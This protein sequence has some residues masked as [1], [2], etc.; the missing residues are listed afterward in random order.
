M[1]QAARHPALWKTQVRG[2]A[3]A[4]PPMTVGDM[5]ELDRV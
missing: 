1:L 5:R 2:G 3:S 4:S